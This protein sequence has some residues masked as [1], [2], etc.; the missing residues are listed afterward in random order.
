MDYERTESEEFPGAESTSLDGLKGI[1]DLRRR[2]YYDAVVNYEAGR[3]K[4]C[5]AKMKRILRK[6]Y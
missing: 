4:L 2:H 5:G 6:G 1:V 3:S